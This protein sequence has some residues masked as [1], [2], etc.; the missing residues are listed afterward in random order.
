MN[1]HAHSLH[2]NHEVFTI[3][4]LTNTALKTGPNQEKFSAFSTIRKQRPVVGGIFSSLLLHLLVGTTVVFH[5]ADLSF[6]I[7]DQ[8]LQGEEAPAV[9]PH[10][11]LT[12]QGQGL[13]RRLQ[14]GHLVPVPRATG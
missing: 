10:R 12:G 13:G 6:V 8:V 3:I 4:H 1:I 14:Q 2:N 9:C 7:P 5:E 11:H